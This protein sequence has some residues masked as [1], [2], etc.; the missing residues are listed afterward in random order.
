MGIQD[1]RTSRE[2]LLSQELLEDALNRTEGGRGGR[3]AV[4]SD[5]Q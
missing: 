1:T 4:P 2:R 5:D 3:S